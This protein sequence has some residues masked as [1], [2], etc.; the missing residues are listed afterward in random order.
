MGPDII[1]KHYFSRGCRTEKGQTQ[2]ECSIHEKTLKMASFP[3]IAI[4]LTAGVVNDAKICELLWE[5]CVL[6]FK[7][8]D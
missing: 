6:K 7:N 8:D 1:M 2:T 3:V 4:I 5:N